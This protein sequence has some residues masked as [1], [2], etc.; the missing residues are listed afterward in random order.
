MF[1]YLLCDVDVDGDFYAR[2]TVKGSSAVGVLRGSGRSIR[3]KEVPLK[4]GTS[5]VVIERSKGELSFQVGTKKMAARRLGYSWNDDRS[6]E[7]IFI[8]IPR[9]KIC[10]LSSV[11]FYQEPKAPA[12]PNSNSRDRTG[13]K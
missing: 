10:Y 3:G 5:T 13:R 11:Q 1:G 2:F 12:P 9:R 8:R 7:R 4:G 6:P